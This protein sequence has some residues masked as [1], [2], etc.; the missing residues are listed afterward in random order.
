MDINAPAVQLRNQRT[1]QAK[2]AMC[3]RSQRLG[4]DCR[5]CMWRIRTDGD[6]NRYRYPREPCLHQQTGGSMLLRSERLQ[7]FAQSLPCAQTSHKGTVPF[8][9]RFFRRAETAVG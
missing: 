5:V 9:A 1:E 3:G 8:A 6:M 7:G 4:V 2:I